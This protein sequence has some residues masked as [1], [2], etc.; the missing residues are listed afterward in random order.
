VSKAFATRIQTKSSHE[1]IAAS[2][3]GPAKFCQIMFDGSRSTSR[4]QTSHGIAHSRKTA[5]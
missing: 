4:V 5:P 2:V 3:P 1:A